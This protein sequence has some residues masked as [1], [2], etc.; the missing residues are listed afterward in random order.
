MSKKFRTFMAMA[1]GG[2]SDRSICR[3]E[4][5][6]KFAWELGKGQIISIPSQVPPL[7]FTTKATPEDMPWCGPLQVVS[8]RLRDLIQTEFPDHAQFIP[9]KVIDNKYGLEYFAVNWI[10][11][12]GCVDLENSEVLSHEKNEDG[13]MEY[14]FDRIVLDPARV[15]SGIFIFR[16][17]EM[18]VTVVCDAVVRD[19][20]RKHK[21]T[22]PQFRKGI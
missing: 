7:K 17:K 13:V 14:D 4:K 8:K 6:L 10:H 18:P 20:F 19:V 15:P 1:D 2:G 12:V 3:M 9:L 21:I 22:G 16:L 5:S 11:M